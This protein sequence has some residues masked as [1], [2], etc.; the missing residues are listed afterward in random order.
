VKDGPSAL[1]RPMS[2]QG[3]LASEAPPGRVIMSRGRSAGTVRQRRQTLVFRRVMCG[4][5]TAHRLGA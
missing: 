5:G 4:P 3:G 2:R 1:A